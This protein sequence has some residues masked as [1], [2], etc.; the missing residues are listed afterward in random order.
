[1]L[2]LGVNNVKQA[3]LILILLAGI[4]GLV[5]W[6]MSGDDGYE[7]EPR[8]QVAIE[9]GKKKSSGRPKTL[10]KKR[11]EVK[12]A[13]TKESPGQKEVKPLAADQ[14]PKPSSGIMQPANRE[15]SDEELEEIETYLDRVEN[16]WNDGMKDLIVNDF[17]LSE[18]EYNAYLELRDEY[19]E[20]KLDDYEKWHEGMVE[21]HG[22]DYQFRPTEVNESFRSETTVV[23][24]EKLREKWGMKIINAISN[25]LIPIMKVSGRREVLN[26]DSFSSIYNEE[27]K[28]FSHFSS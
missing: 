27:F 10:P 16:N 23:Y 24:L 21:K 25:I 5:A 9:V 11:P 2:F 4:G 12:T 20:A 7:S 1:M 18:D 8:S 17:G 28:T 22:S 3:G 19:E 13:Q 26:R 14:T 6:L 15:L